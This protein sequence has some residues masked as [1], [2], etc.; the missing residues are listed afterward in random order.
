MTDASCAKRTLE[1][2]TSFA[3]P[4]LSCTARAIARPSAEERIPL[5]GYT[6]I[7]SVP[8]L[9]NGVCLRRVAAVLPGAR[10]LPDFSA[11]VLDEPV[12]CSIVESARAWRESMWVALVDLRLVRV[13]IERI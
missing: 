3:G 5:H 12:L 9:A 11:S 8:E 1:N 10:S 7:H 13:S 6:S 4:Y 2:T